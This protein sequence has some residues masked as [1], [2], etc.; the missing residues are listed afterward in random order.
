MTAALDLHPDAGHPA[1]AAAFEVHGVLDLLDLDRVE[2]MSAAEAA[3]AVAEWSRA[4][5][6]IEAVRL[7][8]VAAA[9]KARVAEADGLSGTD[10]WLT[11][12]TRS[13]RAK[14]ARD[15]RLATELDQGHDL[16]EAALRSGD[17]SSEHA[18]VIV[19]AAG[20]LPVGLSDSDR[21]RVEF[22]LIEKA[23]QL[24]PGQLRRVARRALEA[25]EPDPEVVD[26]H[27][28]ALLREEEIGAYD[29]S[30]L[31]LH[32]NDDGTTTGHFTVPNAAG[33][34]L[35]KIIDLMTAPRRGRLGASAAQVGP[36]SDRLDWAARAGQAFVELLEH[37][38]TDHLHS[39]TSVTVVA[40][41]DQDKLRRDL[42]AAALDT[43]IDISAGDLRRLA[44]AAKIL[45]AVLDGRSRVLDLGRGQRLFSRSQDIAVTIN[46]ATCAADGCER[47]AAWCDLHHRKA[48]AA[49]GR[50]DISEAVPLCGF[51]H[52]RIHDRRYGHRYGSD[53]SVTFFLRT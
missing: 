44:C 43:G 17:I 22:A 12:Q 52:R 19:A 41:I 16:T 35:R 42:G 30:R 15:L 39:R 26:E 23:R 45:P 7:K 33:S 50:T 34:I 8:L 28:G 11:R 18:A 1:V 40:T 29:R 25:V 48:W 3:T 37:L 53:D 46:H 51:H 13:G 36:A 14:A 38:P 31:T 10:A 2:G 20:K 9:D 24:D 4:A 27:Q 32:D 5:S 47:P 21:A 49:G 6:R